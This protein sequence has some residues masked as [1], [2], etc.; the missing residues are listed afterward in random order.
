[1]KTRGLIFGFLAGLAIVAA[2]GCQRNIV[3]AEPTSVASPPHEEPLPQPTAATPPADSEPVP[4]PEPAASTPP[5]IEIEPQPAPPRPRPAPAEAEA[6][7]PKPDAP[8]PEIAPQLSARQQADAT[9]RTTDAVR[10]AEKNLQASTGKRLNASQKDL[11]EKIQDF[12][13]QA[14]EA[15]RANDWVRAENLAQKAQVLSAEL[16]KAL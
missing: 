10:V 7:K 11:V 4:V 12:L 8:A 13:A 5:P 2:S 16:L 6:P 15:I 9:R 14:H 1:M 3:R